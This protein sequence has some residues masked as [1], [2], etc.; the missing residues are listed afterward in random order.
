MIQRS[1]MVDILLLED[2]AAD[3][4]LIK[5]A[6]KDYNL[7]VRLHHVLDGREGLNFLNRQEDYKN[8]PYPDLIFLD[9]NMPRMNGYEFLAEIK[10]DVRFKQIPVI[11][12]TTSDIEKDITYCYQLGA[13]SF[14]TKPTGLDQFVSVIHKTVEYWMKIV[15]LPQRNE[16]EY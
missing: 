1:T 15:C 10:K 6:F 16:H 8:A 7:S 9:L 13:A 11:V 12:L 5:M 14:I 4:Y 2:E 3:A